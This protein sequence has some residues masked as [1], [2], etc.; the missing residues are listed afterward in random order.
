MFA[1]RQADGIKNRSIFSEQLLDRRLCNA[2]IAP[3]RHI[4][5]RKFLTVKGKQ[6]E[7]DLFFSGGLGL[8]NDLVLDGVYALHLEN[9]RQGSGLTQQIL[10]GAIPDNG[11][12]QKVEKEKS[13]TGGQHKNPCVP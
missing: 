7:K 8:K 4:G 11:S 2:D 13:H 6:T 10:I 5:R 12:N 1:L 3:I 9:R